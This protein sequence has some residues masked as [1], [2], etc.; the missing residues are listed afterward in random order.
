MSTSRYVDTTK[1]QD[2]QPL[3]PTFSSTDTRTGYSLRLALAVIS[4]LAGCT[5]EPDVSDNRVTPLD[6]VGSTTCSD[7]HS[8]QYERWQGSHHQL[9][10]QAADPA[11]VL[12]DFDNVTVPYFESAV[13]LSER[14]GRFFA[15]VQGDD[16]AMREFEIT[17]TFGHFPLQQYLVD[18][19]Q[20][21]KQALQFAWDSRAAAIGGQRWFHLYADEYVDHDDPLHWSGRHFNW[22]YMCAECHSTDVQLGYDIDSD[23]YRTT[24][25]EIS[26]GCEAC[27]GPGSKHVAQAHSGQFDEKRGLAI[28]F[29]DRRG[30]SWVMEPTSR[31]ARRSI[32]NTQRVETDACGRCHSRRAVIDPSYEY[33]QPLT[34]THMPALLDEHLYYPDGRIQDEVYVYGSFLQSKMY[35]AGVTCSDCH[36]PHSGQ[37]RTGPEPNAICSTCHS[38]K[39]Y[40]SEQHSPAAIGQCVDCHMPSTTYMVVDDRRDHSFRIPNAGSGADHYGQIIA[41]GREGRGHDKLL[42]GIANRSYP[43]IARATMLS[44]LGPVAGAAD[45]ELL[46]AQANDSDPLVR[47]ATLRALRQQTP[48]TIIRTG[49][50]LLRDPIRAVR[51]EAALTFRDYRDFMPIED[52]RAFAKAADEYRES[53]AASAFMPDAAINLALFEQGLGNE[54]AA[55]KLFEHAMRIGAEI[56]SVQ[57]AYGLH[58]VRRGDALSAVTHLRRAAEINPDHPPFVYAYGVALNSTGSPNKAIEV[59]TSA[60]LKF[61]DDFDIAWALVTMLRDHGDLENAHSLLIELQDQFPDSPQLRA[62]ADSL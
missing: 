38:P 48:E 33:G 29:S 27:H 14:D 16:G 2:T 39:H 51:L 37:L 11:T 23:A 57:Y 25:A 15:T 7:C 46:A 61:P 43:G 18:V 4:C 55:A 40:A 56:A 3:R 54:R 52:A 19:G 8:T 44:L 1:T 28:D 6:F 20:G 22:N 50:H 42:A 62:L 41:A 47:I 36:D 32:G 12:G 26:V 9:A 45:Q 21:R 30:V 13:H 17:H 24:F 59:L 10:M 5:A 53:L 31:I 58:E 34:D 49:T 35:A 60:R